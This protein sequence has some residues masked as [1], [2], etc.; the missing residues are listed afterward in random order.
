MLPIIACAA[1]TSAALAQVSSSTFHKGLAAGD[2][3]SASLKS[4]A[5]ITG[6]GSNFLGEL[7]VPPPNSDFIALAT[8]G[9]AVPPGGRVPAQSVERTVGLKRDGSVVVWGYNFYDQGNIPAPNSGFTA[10]SAGLNHTLAL[11]SNGSVAAWGFNA[12]NQTSVPTPNT[13]FTAVSAGLSHSIGLKSDGSVIGWGL[14]SSG[15]TT[16]PFPNTNFV[17]ISAGQDFSVGLKADGSIACWG[18]N[19]YGQRNVPTPNADFVAVSAGA[20]HVSALKKDGSV[21]T[22]G[23]NSFNQRLLPVPNADFVA[24]ASGSNHTLGLKKDGSIVGW[25]ANYQGQRTIPSPNANFALPQV[26]TFDAASV[27]FGSLQRGQSKD[28]TITV[29]NTAAGTIAGF[30]STAGAFSIVGDPTY[31]LAYGESNTITLRFSPAQ[32]DIYVGEIHF[33]GGAGVSV[34][35]RGTGTLPPPIVTIQ[36]VPQTVDFAAQVSFLVEATY[37][38]TY[39]WQKDGVDLANGNGIT[40]A[41]TTVLKLDPVKLTDAGSYRCKVSN[42]GG[43]VFSQGAAL[44]VQLNAPVATITKSVAVANER[45]LISFNGRGS[46][47][48]P[49]DRY[50]WSYT[51][52]VAG[53]PQGS[54]L[55]LGTSPFVSTSSI[56]VGTWRVYFS[57]GDVRNVYSP[58]AS[59]DLEIK[60]VADL[61]DLTILRSNSSLTDARGVEVWNPRQG[62]TIYAETRIQNLGYGDGTSADPIIV[63]IFEDGSPSDLTSYTT[64]DYQ[65]VS[66]GSLNALASGQVGTIR[67]PVVIGRN[68]SGNLIPGYNDGPK[69]LTVQV[70]YASNRLQADAN[71]VG[72]LALAMPNPETSYQNNQTSFG[73]YVGDVVGAGGAYSMNLTVTAPSDI[74][75]NQNCYAAGFAKYAW[76]TQ[77]PVM[78][79]A[80]T[81]EIQGGSLDGRQASSF[82]RAPD[83]TFLPNF[84]LLPEGTYLIKISVFDGRLAGTAFYTVHVHPLPPSGGGGG[85]IGGGG[86]GGGGIG[87]GG[88]GGGGG[89]PPVPPPPPQ[90]VDLIVSDI[91]FSGAGTYVNESGQQ[92]GLVSL[93]I[94]I[95]ALI[96]NQGNLPATHFKVRLQQKAA[97]EVA[98]TLETINLPGGLVAG[99]SAWVPLTA[100]VT[101]NTLGNKTVTATADID[102]EVV[103]SNEFNNTRTEILTVDPLLPDLRPYSAAAPNIRFSTGVPVVGQPLTLYT[104]VSNVGPAALPSGVGFDVT[105][106]INGV[107][108]YRK[109]VTSGIPQ[110]GRIPLAFDLDTT[111]FVPYTPYQVTVVAD[112]GAEVAELNEDNNVIQTSLTLHQPIELQNVKF[113]PNQVFPSAPV[114][115]SS[116]AVNVGVYDIPAGTQVDFYQRSVVPEN[117]IGFALLPAIGRNGRTG[118][119][120]FHWLAAPPVPGPVVIIAVQA[121][122]RAQNTLQVSIVPLPN[123]RILSRDIVIKPDIPH[124]GDNITFSATTQNIATEQVTYTIA[125]NTVANFYIDTPNGYRQLGSPVVLGDI[126]PGEA[127]VTF[128]ATES[129][130]GSDIIYAVIVQLTHDGP[131]RDV[132]DDAATTSFSVDLPI[133]ALAAPLLVHT[134]DLVVLDGATSQNTTAYAWEFI[135]KPAGST[136]IFNDPA[137]SRPTFVADKKGVYRVQLKVSNAYTSQT[138]AASIEAKNPAIL[139]VAQTLDMGGVEYGSASEQTITLRNTG[140][141]SLAGVASVGAPFTIVSGGSYSLAPGASSSLV[142]RF[143]PSSTGNFGKTLALT[144]ASGALVSVTGVGVIPPEYIA[145]AQ[146]YGLT[147]ETQDPTLDLDLDGLTNFEEWKLG[148][149][150]VSF[151]SRVKLTVIGRSGSNVRLQ[152]NQVAPNGVY[153]LRLDSDGNGTWDSQQVFTFSQ[154][155]TDFELVSP[156]AAGRGTYQMFWKPSAT[157]T[158]DYAVS[159]EVEVQTL[160][161]AGQGANTLVAVPFLQHAVIHDVVQEIAGQTISGTIGGYLP[162]SLANR[163]LLR[164]TNGISAGN[165]LLVS[166]NTANTITVSGN[167]PSM[168]AHSDEYEVI[169]LWTLNSLF[170]VIPGIGPSGLASGPSAASADTVSFGGQRYFYKNAGINAPGWKRESAP[171]G[172]ADLGETV[173]SNLAGVIIAR[174]GTSTNLSVQ[175]V[176]RMGRAFL[177]IPNGT[178]LLS[179][180]FAKQTSLL[181]SGL[182]NAL[183]GADTALTADKVIVNGLRYF[184]KTAGLGGVGWRLETNPVALGADQVI[185][186]PAGRAFNIIRAGTATL[187]EIPEPSG[188]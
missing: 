164:V 90:Y 162:D 40:D 68:A 151:A 53:V 48:Y 111:G 133:P 52:L 49:V 86:I 1:L 114:D 87:G 76:G 172:A 61:P 139:S 5:T 155:Q 146:G 54:P 69:I 72:G 95:R 78:G 158:T 65:V 152:L 183:Q 136:A 142:I 84:G 74:Y 55:L 12:Y 115:I 97:N 83:G 159:N 138:T 58:P 117:K 4:D 93:P 112:A 174:R 184:Y 166:G 167:I 29:T 134:G 6:W 130:D 122:S 60:D 20:F 16:T 160:S 129:V 169:P 56:P 32:N 103:E 50:Q 14:N 2:S 67:V 30:V 96:S 26:F 181:D 59:F 171:N 187:L 23:N 85:G 163:Y 119:A 82:S 113:Q 109:R 42:T 99:G 143:S 98:T 180:P 35:I 144:G 177:P 149:N 157:L 18:T 19:V 123:L 120:T 33:T 118:T 71:H 125:R 131:D 57:V 110:G 39:R 89:N 154:L 168:T 36:P 141:E 137:S 147:A 121:Y 92:R 44:T 81:A 34:P 43:T 188:P 80:V 124:R 79:A 91:E 100:P 70:E 27:D 11:R 88:I 161:V 153:I 10:V 28:A 101:W 8:A 126:Y 104:D 148:T 165:E 156:N 75:V 176:P 186:N 135:E 25:G 41:D 22:W 132:S 46:G 106:L 116:D 94:Q 24:I 140:D 38:T 150:P 107:E 185:I 45:E 7:T 105:V 182:Q 21:V 102:D 179:W 173:I 127:N 51:R 62:D 108:F 31:A 128:S 178:S 9:K 13:G 15:Q 77:V 175:G 3:H 145:W 47:A 17:A 37:G 63:T 170:R 64:T 66:G 73:I